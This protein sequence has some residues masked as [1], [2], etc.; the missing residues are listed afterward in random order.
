MQL[1]WSRRTACV[2]TAEPSLPIT[3]GSIATTTTTRRTLYWEAKCQ[4]QEI[5]APSRRTNSTLRSLQRHHLLPYGLLAQ[6]APPLQS[7]FRRLGL[8]RDCILEWRCGSIVKLGLGRPRRLYPGCD[9][10]PL[11]AL[12][13]SLPACSCVQR[14]SG[15]GLAQRPLQER[16]FCGCEWGGTVPCPSSPRLSDGALDKDLAGRRSV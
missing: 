10:G 1:Q 14:P 12:A 9:E 7:R 11:A 2:S 5:C 8:N 6:R 15:L 3:Q 16:H 4:S 13:T